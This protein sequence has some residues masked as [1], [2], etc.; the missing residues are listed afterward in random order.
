MLTRSLRET[1]VQPHF[2]DLAVVGAGP[3]GSAAALSAARAGLSVIVFDP[4][5]ETD[6]PCGEG[7][8]PPGVRALREL[9]LD[10]VLGAGRS[11]DSIRYRVEGALPLVVPLQGTGISLQRPRLA[12]WLVEALSR[13]PRV[14]LVRERAV[15]ERCPRGGFALHAGRESFRARALVVAD[16]GQGSCAPW[17]RRD[18]ARPASFARGGNATPTHTLSGERIG[19][20]MRSDSGER[21]G[22]RM[23]SGSGERIGMRFR[24]LAAEPLD[25]VEVHLGGGPEI[26][27]TPLPDGIV[28][29]AV[30]FGRMPEGARGTSELLEH[31]LAAHPAAAAR[32]GETVT[33]PACRK[34][35]ARRRRVAGDAT[36]AVGDAGGGVDP[37]L[38]CG[39]S[40]ALTTGI[41]AGRAAAALCA[42]ADPGD[43]DRM[44]RRAYRRDTHGRRHLALFL[45]AISAHRFSARALVRLGRAAPALARALV[46]IAIGAC[47]T[48]ARASGGADVPSARYAPS[49][50]TA[51]A[52][53]ASGSTESAESWSTSAAAAG[54]CRCHWREQGGARWAS[55]RR[56]RACAPHATQRETHRRRS[57]A[58]AASALRS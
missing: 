8:L 32:L 26:Y 56:S 50:R 9:D 24:A 2:F 4:R 48:S 33:R 18:A 5:P 57:C 46:G 34:L 51:R 43:V 13:E 53:C 6:K 20:R 16:G 29:V 42:G 38:G 14:E 7:I 52:S 11:F 3:G 55:T 1:A 39:V 44:Y 15:A 36:F 58:R 10:E 37:I 21:I 47:T 17:L 25:A 30:L 19:I 22:I 54:S 45:R 41:Q 12:A 27:L 23:R 28:N 49:T 40:I 35:G 31:A